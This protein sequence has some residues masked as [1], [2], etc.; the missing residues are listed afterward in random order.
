MS[1]QSE[2]VAPI[3][4]ID[5]GTTNS[6]VAVCDAAGPR[7]L[8]GVAS[9]LMPSVVRY[10]IDGAITVGSQ[11]K[12]G[13]MEFADR[14][15]ASSKR[16]IG[17]TQVE[18]QAF[19]IAQGVRLCEGPRGL[20]AFEVDGRCVLPQ[21]VS[22]AVLR[23]LRLRA[24]AE[25]GMPITRAVITVPAYFDDAQRQA[26]RDAAR[27]AG[28]SVAR[29][30]HEPTAASLAYGLGRGA[31]VGEKVVIYDLGGGTFDCTLLEI[32]P[33]DA[34][35]ET[36]CFQVLATSGDTALGG[37]DIDR[38]IAAHWIEGSA[39][40]Q[41]ADRAR[42]LE[43]AQRAKCALASAESV[44]EQILLG[45]EIVSLSLSR[46]EL[47]TITAP[48]I[49]RTLACC[50]RVLAD[51]ALTTDAIAR[52]VLVGGSTRLASVRREVAKLFGKEPYL[53]L[54]PDRVVALGAAI[55]GAIL[56][57]N[58]RDLLLLDVLP[59]SLGLETVGGATAKLLMRNTPIPARAA[60][61]FSTSIDGQT[62]VKLHV[63]QGE[64]EF[65]EHC[66]SLATFHLTGLPP[67]PAGIPQLE[68]EFLVDQNGVLS[69]YAIERRSGAAASVQIVP[70]YGLTEVE[71]DRMEADSITYAR[72]DMHRHR[73]TDLTVHSRLDIKWITDALGRVRAELD[74]SYVADL[75]QQ[76]V[77]LA[78]LC[79]DAERDPAAIDAD[80]FSRLKQALDTSS[81]RVHEVAI[82]HSI[83]GSSIV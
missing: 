44:V 10:E 18:M 56:A 50:R 82:A 55:Q 58:R 15:I 53:A 3:I 20:A 9:A 76:L 61:K 41:P 16:Y 68:V 31:Q 24:E 1:E 19:A 5:L 11:A 12:A 34:E 59:L 74:P 42:L 13:A 2:A 70:S 33:K 17:R 52:I 78:R 49:A 47:E 38:A 14:T 36:D 23:A 6:L 71:V 79:N 66:R 83:R 25:L 48:F 37:D 81:V 8:G 27:L 39:I 46:A 21:E 30:V 26:T 65:I 57:G 75:E 7:V 60:E 40:P 32:V 28:L 73:V 45:G 80:L 69:V 43:L 51:A 22:A 62:S 63:V 67:M 54:D 77:A 4:G 64:R 29:L 35:L 72:S